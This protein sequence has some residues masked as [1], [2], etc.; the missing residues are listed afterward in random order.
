MGIKKIVSFLFV[1]VVEI[2]DYKINIHCQIL[3]REPHA[4]LLFPG[5]LHILDSRVS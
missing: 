5:L 2:K 4:G 1:T 3:S